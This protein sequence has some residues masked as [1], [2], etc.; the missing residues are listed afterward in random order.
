MDSDLP[1]PF[2]VSGFSCHDAE[3]GSPKV[4]WSNSHNQVFFVRPE[5]YDV[6]RSVSF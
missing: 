2:Q 5:K 4:G 1:F 6:K 3:H